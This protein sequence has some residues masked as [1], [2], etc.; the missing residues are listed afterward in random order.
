MMETDW[1]MG[2]YEDTSVAELDGMMG[3]IYLGASGLGSLHRILY[4]LISHHPITYKL[5]TP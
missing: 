1:A 3:S 4:H 2:V 5:H